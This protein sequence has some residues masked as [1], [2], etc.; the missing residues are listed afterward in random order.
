VA[1]TLSV[2]N[3]VRPGPPWRHHDLGALNG[4]VLGAIGALARRH[5]LEWVIATGH[6]SGGL[7]VGEDPDAGGDGLVLPMVDYE[8][9]PPPGLD[10]E[11]AV[12]AGG[13]EDRG[14]AIMGGATH[15]ARQ[16]L[17]MER[18]APGAVA[19]ARWHLGIPQY[20]AWRLSGV[21][22]SEPSVLGA[23][24]Q[25]WNVPERRASPIVRTRGWERL[26]PPMGRAWD[27]LGPVRPGLARAHGLP[28]GLRVHLGAHDSSA[29]AYRYLAAGH[30]ALMVV[31]TGTWIVAL[32]GGVPM[33]R[34]DEGRG[35]TINADLEGRP[36]GGALAMGG[37]AF[38][39]I[40]GE[41]D[42]RP[43]DLGAVARLVARGTMALPTWGDQDGPF[44]GTAGRGQVV[45]PA[46]EGPA[47][48]LAL[49]LLHVALLTVTLTERL[50]PDRAVVL[51]GSFLSEP[52]FAPL[53]AALRPGRE[54]WASPEPYG[55][56][57]GAA[58]I[59]G[60]LSRDGPAEVPLRA[61]RPAVVP[62]LQDHARRW[63]GLATGTQEG[64]PKGTP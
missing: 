49:A 40:A 43:A 53:V 35:M 60:H 2:E 23:Q 28:G 52:L 50:D 62:G 3:P 15:Q 47:E 6:G 38:A 22:R 45:G 11:Y 9:A 54:T 7:L 1:E 20:W 26:L 14:S 37:R 56:A 18:E 41:R 29:N 13:F 59:A 25:L 27:D 55:V 17:W 46:P 10:A 44:P 21:A 5:P 64:T 57:A 36:V 58:L 19:R 24:S 32:A 12:L 51:D 33:A 48:R 42:G 30:G 63:T 61:V 8:Q 34:L 39:A 4:W 16:L 31:S